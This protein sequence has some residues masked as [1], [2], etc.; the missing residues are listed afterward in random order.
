MCR[1][2]LYILAV[3]HV[4]SFGDGKNGRGKRFVF[5][6]CADDYRYYSYYY[7]YIKSLSFGT[8]LEYEFIVSQR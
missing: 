3:I 6:D 2:V 8:V 5:I 4:P 7:K 1:I